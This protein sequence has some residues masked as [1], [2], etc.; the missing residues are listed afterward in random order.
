[1]NIRE[2]AVQAVHRIG[3]P[4]ERIDDG[5]EHS[6]VRKGLE[7]F[8]PGDASLLEVEGRA[9]LDG[10]TIG[11][12]A[13]LIIKGI[14]EGD[15]ETGLTTMSLLTPIAFLNMG[16]HIYLEAKRESLRRNSNRGNNGKKD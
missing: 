3:K 15:V 12:F 16:A 2:R 8:A 7:P 13:R 1:M 11:L 5:I 10:A 4:I 9:V 14:A 6:P